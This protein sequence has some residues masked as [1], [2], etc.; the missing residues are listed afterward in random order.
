MVQYCKM[1]LKGAAT[2]L[3]AFI[4]HFIDQRAGNKVRQTPRHLL[5]GLSLGQSEHDFLEIKFSIT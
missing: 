3:I 4:L 2:N 5:K 1:P